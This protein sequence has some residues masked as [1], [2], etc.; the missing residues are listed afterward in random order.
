MTAINDWNSQTSNNE[1]EEEEEE[2]K[3]AKTVTIDVDD[4]LI[5]EYERHSQAADRRMQGSVPP[6]GKLNPIK[7]N[8]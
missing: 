1:E 5:V 8:G 2:E 6:Q 3:E 7:K 4:V